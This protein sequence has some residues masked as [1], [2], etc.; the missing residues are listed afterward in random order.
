MTKLFDTPEFKGSASAGKHLD[1]SVADLQSRMRQLNRRT[2]QV[3]KNLGGGQVMSTKPH[4]LGKKLKPKDI[5]KN[6]STTT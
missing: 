1:A 5:V 2:N 4:N 3:S 6:I